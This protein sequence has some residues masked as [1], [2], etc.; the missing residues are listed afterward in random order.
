MNL[1]FSGKGRRPLHQTADER[2]FTLFMR[3]FAQW[4]RRYWPEVLR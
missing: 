1:M 4:A 3:S 2:D